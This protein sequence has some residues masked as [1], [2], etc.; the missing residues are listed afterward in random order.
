GGADGGGRLAED[1]GVVAAA[2]APVGGED[3]QQAVADLLALDQQRVR[4]VGGG[5]AEVGDHLGDLA[6][7][8]GGVGG[9]IHRPPVARRRDQFHRAGDLLDVADRLAA[10]D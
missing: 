1:A 6:H 7:V 10:L 5:G 3:Q 2:Q 4:H 9:A 8:G